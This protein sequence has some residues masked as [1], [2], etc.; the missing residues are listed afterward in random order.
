MKLG[1]LW[2]RKGRGWYVNIDGK[3]VRLAQT[4]ESAETKYL[5]LKA[6]ADLQQTLYGS[7]HPTLESVLLLSLIHI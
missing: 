3:Q 5:A 6:N 7:K 4:R 1:K 2:E